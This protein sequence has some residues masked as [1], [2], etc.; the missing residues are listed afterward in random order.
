MKKHL[1]TIILVFIFFVGLAVLLYP[2]VSNI[3]NNSLHSAVISD[4]D[5]QLGTF[6]E[7][8]YSE[9]WD[10]AERYNAK[11]REYGSGMH[12]TNGEPQDEEYVKLLD[13]IGTGMMGYIEIPSIDVSLPIYHGTS[14]SV[15][16]AG[17]GHLEGSS[18]PGGGA[19][20]H[21]ILSGHRGL[22]SAKLFTD[23][24]E[25]EIGDLFYIHVL[26]RTLT[27]MVDDIS[28]VLPS[29]V[30]NLTLDAEKDYVTLVTCTPYGVNS[31]RLLVRGTRVDSDN[32]FDAATQYT[33]HVYK[34]AEI[35]G[36]NVIAPIAAVPILLLF[37]I[38]VLVR[39]RHR[40]SS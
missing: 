25:L 4:Y 16:A 6:T 37:L 19:G 40:K 27:Y 23:L 26:D 33:F 7:K 29:E 22:P 20:T 34:D 39:Y 9:F 18:L 17:V 8:D 1:S 36:V 28:V 5:N 35:Y 32:G 11:L 15:L 14:A 38:Y 21:M 2:S 3:Y 13:V 30:G 12:F 31:H 24:D 10:G